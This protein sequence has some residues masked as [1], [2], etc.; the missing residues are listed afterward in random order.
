L[1]ALL[2][3]AGSQGGYSLVWQ[4]AF[5]A[6]VV[7]PLFALSVQV[8]RWA[9]ARGELYKAADA[10]ALAASEEVDLPYYQETGVVV[11]RG[12]VYGV[13]SAYANRN[14]GYLGERGIHARVTGISV[15]QGAKTV[16]VSLAADVSNLFPRFLPQV[17]IQGQGEAQAKLQ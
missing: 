3:K 1:R 17:D 16:R 7:G 5:I 12:T 15:D 4:S 14:M 6:L 9:Y 13:A 8:G 2:A 10:A 11:L